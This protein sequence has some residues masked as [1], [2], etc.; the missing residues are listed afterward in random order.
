MYIYFY[1]IYKTPKQ[2]FYSLSF[3]GTIKNRGQLIH[4]IKHGIKD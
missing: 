4:E 2:T 3:N 1:F